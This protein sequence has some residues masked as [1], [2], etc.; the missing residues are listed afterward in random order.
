MAKEAFLTRTKTNEKV[1]IN[2]PDFRIGKLKEHVD[3]AVDNPWISRVHA[4]IA[5]RDGRY[6]IM[7]LFSTNRVYINGAAIKQRVEYE[8]FSG[9]KIR[10]ANE[11]FEFIVE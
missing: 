1:N 2:T 5:T 8:I 9:D 6:F 3:Y 10:L 7:D 11:D 4:S